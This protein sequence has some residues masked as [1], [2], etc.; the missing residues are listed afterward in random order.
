MAYSTIDIGGGANSVGNSTYTAAYTTTDLTNKANASGVLTSFEA[1]CDTST[2][3]FKMGTFT[4]I[5][6]NINDR[7][8]VTWGDL[9]GGSKQTYTGDN[10]DVVTDDYIGAY[11]DTHN[12]N[13]WINSGGSGVYYAAGDKFGTGNF[14]GT[15]NGSYR[16]TVY[17]TGVTVPDAPTSVSATDDLTTKV[18]ITW[19]AGT[20]ETGGHRVYR[21]GADISGIVAHNTATYDDTTGTAGTTYAYTVK[22]INSAGLSSASSANNGTRVS[23]NVAQ[24]LVTI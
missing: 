2:H 5:S 8:Y 7:D 16:L 13:L 4:I 21:D 17:A 20:G 12:T 11:F 1:Y 9:T 14:S 22:A 3:N 10:C 15:L 24:I 19:T 18:T 23:G 6:T